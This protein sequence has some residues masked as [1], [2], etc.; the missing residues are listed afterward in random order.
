VVLEDCK[1]SAPSLKYKPGAANVVADVLLRA[2]VM[3]VETTQPALQLVMEEQRQDGKLE[4]LIRYLDD[5]LLPS[6]PSEAKKV[7]NQS[8]KEYYLMDGMLF[9]EGPD[10][11]D[12]C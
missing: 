9:Y 1:V 7:V 4:R 6:D 2:P 5:D 12:R 8:Q 10:M 3:R 11:P